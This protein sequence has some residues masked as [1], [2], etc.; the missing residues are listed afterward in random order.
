M[1]DLEWA[2]SVLLARFADFYQEVAYIKQAI[3]DGRLPLLLDG[4]LPNQPTDR[5]LAALVSSRLTQKLHLQRLEMKANCTEVEQKA[6]QHALYVMSALADEIFI[7]EVDWTGREHWLPYL[8]EQSLFRCRK[9][10]RHFFELLGELLDSRSRNS[11]LIELAAV[12]LLALQ[13]GFKGEYR[14]AQGHAKLTEY[15][16]KLMQFIASRRHNVPDGEPVFDQAYH[17]TVKEDEDRRLG[18]LKPWYKAGAVAIVLYLI[19]STAVWLNT[20]APLTAIL[21][22]FLQYVGGAS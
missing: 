8:I 6:Y 20:L 2:D 17:Y 19:I 16:R 1:R 7:L 13:L 4:D 9:A 21:K 18:S 14:G 12:F 15:R 10:G 3:A 11:L 22:E 5:D